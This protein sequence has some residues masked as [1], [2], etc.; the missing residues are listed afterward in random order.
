VDRLIVVTLLAVVPLAVACGASAPTA[1]PQPGVTISD[2]QQKD[3][4]YQGKFLGQ[5]VT[6]SSKVADVLGPGVFELSGGNVGA[7]KLTVVTD[8]PVQVSKDD[9]VRVT[10]TV[11]QLHLAA[12][13]EGV[14]YEQRDLYDGH[15]TKP[16]L[17]HATVEPLTAA[18]HSN[19]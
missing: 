9:V 6:L 19:R 5:T 7:E 16:Y 1:G 2:L 12:P 13:S 4:F 15:Q 11:G 17:Y 18:Q 3:Y 10:G 8:Q 14:P